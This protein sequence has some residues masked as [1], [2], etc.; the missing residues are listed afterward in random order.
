MRVIA[1]TYR[2]RTINP[3]PGRITRP[4]TD[5]IREAWA[6][7]VGS[8]LPAGFEGITT[9]DAFAGSGAL[10]I[11]AL[12]R[13]AAHVVF[14]E[15]NSKAVEVLRQNLSIINGKIHTASVIPWDIF[16]SRALKTLG[17]SNPFQLLILD[18]PYGFTAARVSSLLQT[19]I[20]SRLLSDGAL[21]SYEHQKPDDSNSDASV[22]VST[23]SLDSCK[24]V[25]CKTY[26]NTRIEYLIYQEATR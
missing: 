23:G 21:I 25:S 9:L 24:M 18:P 20:C 3:V 17:R 8:L 14:C 10:G 11:E 26:G 1:G 19:I 15:S 4:T 13:G 16:S 12:S 7:S 5:R 22:L 6:S 2:G